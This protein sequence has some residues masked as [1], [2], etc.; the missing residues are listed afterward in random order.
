MIGWVD[1]FRQLRTFARRLDQVVRHVLADPPDVLVPI[2]FSGFNI[3]LLKRLRR[4]VS[5]V[6]YVPPMVSTRRGRRAERVASPWA[7][8]CL[9][10]CLEPPPTSTWAPT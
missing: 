9:R 5:A 6:Y 10:F 7:R 3:A 2:D 1:A 8:A 4:R